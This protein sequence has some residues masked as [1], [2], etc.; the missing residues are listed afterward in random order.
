MQFEVKTLGKLT[1]VALL[2]KCCYVIDH[3]KIIIKHALIIIILLIY[4]APILTKAQSALRKMEINL[5]CFTKTYIYI[6]YQ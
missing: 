3:N 2:V 4:I 6:K 1:V 5:K